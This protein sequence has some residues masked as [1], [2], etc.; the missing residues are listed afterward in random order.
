MS[1]D[2]DKWIHMTHGLLAALHSTA[3]F[4][5]CPDQD[6]LDRSRE[7]PDGSVMTRQTPWPRCC[8]CCS[9]PWPSTPWTSM[10]IHR[11]PA[12]LWC[13][14]C[15]ISSRACSDSSLQHKPEATQSQEASVPMWNSDSLPVEKAHCNEG[16]HAAREPL[17]PAREPPLS[18]KWGRE[19]I[20]S[21]GQT[22]L[23]LLVDCC[24]FLVLPWIFKFTLAISTR[25][26]NSSSQWSAQSHR[27]CR[28]TVFAVQYTK[29][30]WNEAS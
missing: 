9:A 8:Q 3:Q 19:A 28:K 13:M 20:Y 7:D 14:S 6:V 10:S 12:L 4:L 16:S 21:S 22:G 30:F 11:D 15:W 26:H 5:I 29:R 17:F 23:G 25:Q 27:R 24:W 2:I 18:L 1:G